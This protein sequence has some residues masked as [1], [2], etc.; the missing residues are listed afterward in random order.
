MND[1]GTGD[2]NIP[3][4]WLVVAVQYADD[5][6]RTAGSSHHVVSGVFL[7]ARRGVGFKSASN[8][9][10]RRGP[11]TVSECANCPFASPSMLRPC[12]A[13]KSCIEA[14]PSWQRA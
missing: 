5:R 6:A 14:N 10:G 11:N 7:D 8:F 2:N 12:L 9:D 3:E 13:G 4:P 1:V